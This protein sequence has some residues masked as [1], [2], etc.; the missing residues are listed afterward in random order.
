[1]KHSIKRLLGRFAISAGLFFGAVSSASASGL[2]VPRDGSSADIEIRSHEV[3]VTIENGYAVTQIDQVFFNKGNQDTEATYEFPV[4][5]NGTVAEFSLWI[6]GKRVIG[7][8]IEKEQAREV[9]EQ[10]KAAGRDAGLTEQKSFYRFE[11]HVSPVRA[12]QETKTRLVYMQPAD[13][14]GGIGRYVY[15]LEEGGTDEEKLAFWS[16]DNKVTGTFNFDMKLRSGYPVDAVRVP[17]NKSAV[18]SNANAQEWQVQIGQTGKAGKP[19][20]QGEQV[21]AVATDSSAQD[22]AARNAAFAGT[23]NTTTSSATE[24]ETTTDTTTPSSAS[25]LNEDIVV[26]WKLASD[27]PGAIDVT[28][29]RQPGERKG[30]FMMTVTPGIDLAQLNAG[31]DWIFLL[32][33]S[34]SMEGKYSTLLDATEQALGKLGNRDRF[35]IVLFDDQVE[36]L[37][38]GWVNANAI[39]IQKVSEALQ[40]TGPRGGTALYDG[41]SAAMQRLDSDRTS[42]IVLITDGVANVGK[43]ERKDFLDLMKQHDVRLFTAIMGNGADEP[44]LTSMAQVSQGF[45]VSVSNSDDILGVL[46]NALNKVNYQALH[47]ISL[48]ING[49]KTADLAPEQPTTLYRGQQLVLFGHYFGDDEAEVVLKAKIGGEDK[50][51]RT[52]FHFPASATENPEVERLWAFAHIESLK[53]KAAYLGEALDDYRSAIVDTAVEYGL[54]T[55]YTSMVVMRDEQFEQHGIQRQNKQRRETEEQS[56]AVRAAAPVTNN[57]VDSQAPAF[58]SSRPSYTSGGSGGG[59]MGFEL[60]IPLLLLVIPAVRKRLQQ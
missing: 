58:P 14:E 33:R 51:Y 12:Q 29:Y 5:K 45:A 20:P 53:N 49:V 57:R 19:A 24:S 44:L 36:E 52:K 60:L 50:E 30:T 32:D 22:I 13:V 17:A 42:G 2:L 56:A 38:S 35:R 28:A 21:A 34:G 8:V 1:M 25:H 46:T 9:Y 7:E 23:A 16:T 6:D 4:P 39:S 3:N 47:D 10:E 18:I 59:A 55:D 40:Q 26:Y 54:V 11:T 31:R 41:L 48:Q 15:P 27:L 43:T 37:T